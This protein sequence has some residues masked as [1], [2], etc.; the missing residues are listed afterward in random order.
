MGEE[1]RCAETGPNEVGALDA[2]L[3]AIPQLRV[4]SDLVQFWV[5]VSKARQGYPERLVLH[6][7]HINGK[8]L[9]P[10]SW[11]LERDLLLMPR[12]HACHRVKV[13]L[14]LA[15]SI[16]INIRGA[17]GSPADDPT[18][19]Q[20][21][22]SFVIDTYPGYMEPKVF[23]RLFV[24]VKELL[25]ACLDLPTVLALSIQLPLHLRLNVVFSLLCPQVFQDHPIPLLASFT[26]GEPGQVRNR[27]VKDVAHGVEPRERPP[28][29]PADSKM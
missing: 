23:G 17:F 29:I 28:L 3:S 4:C 11:A 2:D 15:A 18:T 12:S 8:L 22:L 25:V 5:L 13:G 9:L 27:G 7:F 16:T 21:S 19:G 24:L 20:E 26:R 14:R 6:I 1:S 10:L